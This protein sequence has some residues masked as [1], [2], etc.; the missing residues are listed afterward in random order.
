[1]QIVINGT[2]TIEVTS[3]TETYFY[4]SNTQELIINV[5][6]TNANNVNTIKS[7]LNA[8][9]NSVCTIVLSGEELTEEVQYDN[10]QLNTLRDSIEAIGRFISITFN[11]VEL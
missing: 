4:E 11:K 7:A 1:M 6:N 2:S 8:L 10:Y 9:E 3:V 5:S